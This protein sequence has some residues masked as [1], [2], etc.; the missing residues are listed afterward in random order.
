MNRYP[1]SPG[2]ILINPYKHTNNLE[3]LDDKSW[4]EINMLA[5]KC[6]KLLKDTLKVHGV[7]IGMN[8]GSASGAGISEHL[9]L[10]V[11]PRW[12]RD[13]NFIS[14]ICDVRVYSSDFNNIY[15]LLYKSFK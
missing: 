3:L 7:N 15:N 6:A 2:H 10:H 4:I 14:T 8:I 5:K 11:V 9:H 12:E 13:T 1:Y